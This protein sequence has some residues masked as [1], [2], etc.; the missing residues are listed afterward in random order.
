MPGRTAKRPCAAW[1]D[2]GGEAA[3]RGKG[4]DPEARRQAEAAQEAAQA[5]LAL[6]DV[7]AYEAHWEAGSAIF[8]FL[9]PRDS[10]ITLFQEMMSQLEP[11]E[12]RTL[13]TARYT[14]GL[15]PAV[16]PS[17]RFSPEATAVVQYRAR[18]GEETGI[19]TVW[20]ILEDGVWKG[21][22]LDMKKT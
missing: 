18:Y 22:G 21:V 16:T 6:I 7:G 20:M 5:W 9:M 8:K 3:G 15:P 13:I 19:V 17:R 2:G 12:S 4:A 11:L 14:P 1:R 10:W